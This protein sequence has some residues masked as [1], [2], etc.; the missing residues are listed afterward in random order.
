MNEETRKQME[1]I[2]YM[3]KEQATTG[4]GELRGIKDDELAARIKQTEESAKLDI[5][6]IVGQCELVFID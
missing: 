1:L 4:A 2:D 6:N 5:K 3:R